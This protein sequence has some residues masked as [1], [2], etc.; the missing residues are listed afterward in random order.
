MREHLSA[1]TIAA[2]IRMNRS[3]DTRA[4]LLV[5]SEGAG[6]DSRFYKRFIDRS[7]CI[8]Q[9]ARGKDAALAILNVL[10]N[11]AFPGIAAVVDADFWRLEN[12][13]PS[14][15]TMMTDTHDLETMLLRSPALEKLLDELGSDQKIETFTAKTGHHVR[16]GLLAA[17]LSIGVLRWVS[18]RDSL[19]LT[20]EGLTFS[21]FI[22]G[23]TLGL[24]QPKFIATV[25]QHSRNP[26]LQQPAALMA[27]VV[28]ETSEPWDICNGH[29]MVKL[30]SMGLR[31]L[32]GSR[33]QDEV[34]PEL[35]ERN[36]RLAF[37][38]THFKDTAL[39]R[40]M[41]DWPA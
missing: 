7:A 14:P 41:Q 18:Y 25:K 17:A 20:F 9:P 30:L 5:E 4:V 28:Q 16:A 26:D 33:K 3:V 22:D 29:D 24:D 36:L 38:D 12:H 10:E 6:A 21:K 31:S 39:Y 32:W 13:T 1:H 40:A 27:Q 15:N 8:I 35:L 23:K 34:K 19:H 37:E 2:E 11:E